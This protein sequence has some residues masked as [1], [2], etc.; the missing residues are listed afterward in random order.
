[1]RHSHTSPE[2][3]DS[4]WG[5]KRL[6]AVL[7]AVPQL[8]ATAVFIAALRLLHHELGQYRLEDL[9]RAF[10]S[11]PRARIAGAFLF[12]ALS[13]AALTAYDMLAIRYVGRRQPLRRVVFAAFEGF[14]FS[15]NVALGGLTGASVRYRLYSGWG[16]SAA[17]VAALVIFNAVSFWLGFLT[18]AGTTLVIDPAAAP[19][20]LATHASM[21]RGLGGLLLG[22]ALAYFSIAGLRRQ[23]LVVARWTLRPPRPMLAVGQLAVAFVDWSLAAAVPFVLLPPGT[24]SFASFLGTFLLAQFAGVISFVPGGIGVFESVMV[25]SLATRLPAGELLAALVVYRLVYYLFPLLTAAALLAGH[26]LL[27]HRPTALATPAVD[28][29]A[30]LVPPTL[31]TAVFLTGVAML[32]SGAA[33]SESGRLRELSRL[34]PLPFIELSNF[35]ASVAGATLL[36]LARG[37]QRR[38]RSSLVVALALLGAGIPLSLLKGLHYAEAAMLAVV[39][40]LLAACRRAFYRKASLLDE[41]FTASWTVAILIV[42]AG[43]AWLAFFS[44]THSQYSADLWWRFA[45]SPEAPRAWRAEVGAALVL[46]FAAGLHLLRPPRLPG[47]AVPG[48]IEQIRPIVARARTTDACLALLGDKQFLFSAS[49]DCALMYGSRRRTW[50]ALGDPI[51]ACDDEKRQLIW[52]FRALSDRNGSWPAFY[53]VGSDYEGTY[54]ELGLG[55]FMLGEQARVSLGTFS[56]EGGSRKSIRGAHRHARHDGLVF[57]VI[58]RHSVPP[59]LAELREVSDE[60]LAG[61]RSGEKGFSLGFFD[62]SYLSS[63]PAAI[64][65]RA[66]KVIAFANVLEAGGQE[67]LSM[68]LMR[69]RAEAPRGVM[70]FLLVELM[71]WG[72]QVGYR[73]FNL[74]MAPLAG[75]GGGQLS[76]LWDRAGAL[77]F[78]HGEHFY[79]FEGLRAFK[80]K[81]DPVWSPR[82]LSCPGGAVL[83]FILTDIVLLISGGP[84]RLVARRPRTRRGLATAFGRLP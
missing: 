12:T 30:D 74:G 55:Q 80:A 46:I 38:Q 58:A 5:T 75:L 64:V 13:Y 40:V 27:R 32:V 68:D 60:W 35:M 45:F 44:H 1:M 2:H 82:Y 78:R 76:P 26:E 42:M 7:H 25:T 56:L 50:V 79:N 23:P 69:Y 39:L 8:V 37:L 72:K 73:W 34:L 52:A 9:K 84:T 19:P 18:L 15:Q 3:P 51:G 11:L 14:A 59:L 67:E 4:P 66:G 47:G 28:R 22:V 29:F 62:D 83:P 65:R 61:K 33:P 41:S 21:L 36:L 54:R 63:F 48:D 24:M 16:P 31:A 10:A 70:D 77:L 49:G 71:L 20:L 6:R 17:E 81:F 57:E 53:E 43:T